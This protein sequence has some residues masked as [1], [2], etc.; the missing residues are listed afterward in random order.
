MNNVMVGCNERPLPWRFYVMCSVKERV[1]SV[2]QSECHTS[3][4]QRSAG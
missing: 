2:P 1:Q 3:P 4:L